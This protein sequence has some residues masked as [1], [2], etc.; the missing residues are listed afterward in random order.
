MKIHLL[1]SYKKK[2]LMCVETNDYLHCINKVWS[3]VSYPVAVVRCWEHSDEFT[4]MANLISFI[5]KLVWSD[6]K[7]C[8]P[9]VK[10]LIK[11]SQESEP[12][13]LGLLT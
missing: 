11:K 8:K 4:I 12:N 10:H 1:F 13:R 2:K 6:Q 3:L 9:Q 7:I 5:L